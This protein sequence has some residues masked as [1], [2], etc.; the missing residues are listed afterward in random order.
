MNRKG[1][2]LVGG[3]GTR[4]YPITLAIPKGLLPIYDVPMIY[5]SICTLMLSN[6][7]EILII[8]SPE[9]SSR[10]RELLGDGSSWGLHIEYTTQAEPR[11]IAEALIL[12]DDF[13]DGCPS[14]LILGDNIFYGDGFSS[15]LEQVSQSNKNT[16][17]A[18]RVEDPERF[19]ICEF[20]SDN[21]VISLEEKPSKPK[22]NFA[23][24]GL[25]FYD[26]DAPSYARDLTPSAR[27]ELEITD[28]NIKYMDNKE[29]F[30]ETFGEGYTWFDA[31]TTKS[32]LDAS[33]FSYTVES[34]QNVKVACPEEI[35]FKKKLISAD[36]VLK[37]AH[38]HKG[39]DYGKYLSKLVKS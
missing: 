6:I 22:S 17:F 30:V 19:G 26:G 34:R 36:T 23:V 37:L 3:E 20:N 2:I 10:F 11:G 29:L 12:A 16:V 39:N 9:G 25:Y 15:K 4:L 18:Y 7:K 28:L 13:L 27:G 21:K 33:T 8:T 14:A 1:I 35:A 32:F 31:G 24:T 5:H 38:N